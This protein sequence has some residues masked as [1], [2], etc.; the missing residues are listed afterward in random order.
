[1]CGCTC[2]AD[3]ASRRTPC[4]GKIGRT[5]EQRGKRRNGRC[6]STV[7]RED[8]GAGRQAGRRAEAAGRRD[9]AS[10]AAVVFRGML[11]GRFPRGLCY[12]LG[13]MTSP[14]YQILNLLAP[15]AYPRQDI[16]TFQPPP[17]PSSPP[18]SYTAT[19]TGR[20]NLPHTYH[21]SPHRRSYH[22]NLRLAQHYVS[23]YL[24]IC[25]RAY[26]V[27]PYNAGHS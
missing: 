20:P 19:L 25:R 5:F 1:M 21:T 23:L 7:G 8:R 24:S 12:R 15:A 16:Q 26:V 3:D 18:V 13:R 9:T 22:Q 6:W 2:I 14:R 4:V 17:L 27:C 10:L 11:G